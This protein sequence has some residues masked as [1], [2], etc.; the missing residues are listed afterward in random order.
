MDKLKNKIYALLDKH[1]KKYDDAL[2]RPDNTL[3]QD[4][5]LMGSKHEIQIIARHIKN[6]YGTFIYK[7]RI[8]EE[9]KELERRARVLSEIYETE[10]KPGNAT[11]DYIMGQLLAV[12]VFKQDLWQL[13]ADMEWPVYT[14]RPIVVHKEA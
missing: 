8:L 14:T 11:K 2:K 5:T 10:Q 6:I 4:H 7:E 1:A 3:R 13:C 9:V 12:H